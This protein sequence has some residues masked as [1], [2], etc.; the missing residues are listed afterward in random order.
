MPKFA[1]NFSIGEFS[2][3]KPVLKK[4]S[5]I[6]C[7][8]HFVIKARRHDLKSDYKFFIIDKNSI[9]D[10]IYKVIQMESTTISSKFLHF[11]IIID[12]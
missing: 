9:I 2:Q 11:F 4:L 6:Y 5:S 3:L 10:S 8:H 7:Y 12:L 1:F